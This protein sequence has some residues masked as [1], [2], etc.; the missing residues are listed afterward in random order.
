MK[1]IRTWVAGIICAASLFMTLSA[2]D[3]NSV[4]P[5][6]RLVLDAVHTMPRD[7]RYSISSSANRALAS[8]VNTSGVHLSIE[9]SRA[10]PSYCSGA[11]YLVF[12][13]VLSDLELSAR[14][15]LSPETIVSLKPCGQP[16]GT[17][18][19]G[20]WNANGPGTARLFLELGLGPNFT[21]L[22]NARPGDFLKI[23][24]N[25]GIGATEH[26]HSVIFIYQDP[27][28][29]TLT[30]WSSNIPNGYGER[31]VPLRK[32]RRMLF[33]RLEHPEAIGNPLPRTD[34]YLKS[35]QNHSSSQEEMD[36]QC[37]VLR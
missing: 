20:R 30:F 26:G 31:T 37:S 21:D 34:P 10:T 28:A 5:I 24:W 29:G 32:I 1:R 36:R 15:S 9:P 3:D 8:A 11:T 33:S 7:G 13:K 25:D 18:I 16:D 12:L 35:L 6:N 23:F 17:G 19:W 27:K 14:L 4:P 22:A 2:A